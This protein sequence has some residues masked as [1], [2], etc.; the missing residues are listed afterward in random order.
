M[1]LPPARAITLSGTTTRCH[2]HSQAW[3]P[4][5]E[6]P[7]IWSDFHSNVAP[8]IQGYLNEVI[9]PR[10]VARLTPYVTYE[11]VEITQTRGRNVR[12]DVGIWQTQPPP[13]RVAEVAAE[14]PSAPAQSLVSLEFPL[15]LLSVESRATET[16]EL[17]TAI[18]ILSPVNKRKGHEAYHDY[19]RKRREI[20]RSAAHLLEIDLLRGG[21][22]PPQPPL[23][24]PVGG[25][26][27]GYVRAL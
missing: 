1:P 4:Y 10:Y 15:R 16:M 19:Q 20:F 6:G 11:V 25:G 3:T 14:I 26:G 17:V 7:E 24:P 13:R 5:I 27:G 23:S 12:P 18:E 2:P 9:Q 8:E 21:E 22:R